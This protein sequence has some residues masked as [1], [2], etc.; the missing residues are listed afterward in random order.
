[1]AKKRPLLEVSY[2]TPLW[3]L[4]IEE[5]VGHNIEASGREEVNKLLKNGWVLLHIYTLKYNIFR[6]VRLGGL[7]TLRKMFSLLQFLPQ[8]NQ[9]FP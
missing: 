5:L 7:G 2:T 3:E 8:Y 1:M 9:G 4:E 6:Q